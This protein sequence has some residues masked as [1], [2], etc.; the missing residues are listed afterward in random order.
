MIKYFPLAL[1][2]VTFISARADAPAPAVGTLMGCTTS[3]QT[4]TYNATTSSLVCQ[5]PTRPSSTTAG[6]PTCNST[7]LGQ[8][9]IV[10]DALLPVALANIAGGGAVKI[11]VTCNGVNWIVQ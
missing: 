10:T 8:E 11:G 1:F 6:L 9:Y 5:A 3:G 2:F 4:I 7:I